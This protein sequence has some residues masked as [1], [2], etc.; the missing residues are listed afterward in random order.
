M[1]VKRI[2]VIDDEKRMADSLQELLSG[3]DYTVDVAYSGAEGIEKLK[4]TRYHVAITD[5]R[6]AEVNG[7]DVIQHI[8]SY[9]PDTLT[10]IITAHAST[11]SAIEALHYKAFDYI[12][13]PFD[14]D[15][16]KAS[17]EKAF[18]KIEADKLREE[19][20]SMIT[21][22][23]KLPLTSIIGF[24]NMIIEMEQGEISPKIR[25]YVNTIFLNSQKLLSLIDNFLTTCNINVGR[26]TISEAEVAV[27]PV[28]EDLLTIVKLATEKKDIRLDVNLGENLP[29]IL[30]DENLLFRALGNVL[31]NAMKYTPDGGSITVLTGAVK[32]IDSPLHCPSL[33]IT[34]TNTGPGIPR[35]ELDAIFERYKRSKTIKGIE[36][37][38]LGLYVLKH[39]IEAH[40][41]TVTVDSIPNSHTTF[42]VYLPLAGTLYI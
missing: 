14:F 25:E 29:S 22:D 42:A 40:K 15:L 19:M 38:G 24:S 11:E 37:I 10:I 39:I 41:G 27:N 34:V 8:N 16:L 12:T 2:L 35:N 32:A 28:L 7:L 17:V 30:G 5:L 26:L 36:G 13:K 3:Y 21:H 1:D 33:K 6:M 9:T 4:K 23:I 18:M 20:I 31:N